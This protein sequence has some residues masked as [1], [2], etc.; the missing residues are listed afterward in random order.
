MQFAIAVL[1]T[2]ENPE[3]AAVFFCE[4]LGFQRQEE[5]RKQYLLNNGAICIRLEAGTVESR[6]ATL[7]LELYCEDLDESH[8]ALLRLPGVSVITEATWVDE[9]RMQS[10]LSAPHDLKITLCRN[11]NEDELG[12]LPPLPSALVWDECAENCIREVLKQIPLSFRSQARIRITERAEMISGQEGLVRVSL[13][14]AIRSLAETTPNFQH[15]TLCLALSEMG[16]DPA[17]YFEGV[18]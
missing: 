11:F 9:Y 12:I 5:E 16:I 10:R 1:H 15:R 18:E 17:R 2:V 6:R 4:A 7:N 13:D 3:A 14:H 8:Q